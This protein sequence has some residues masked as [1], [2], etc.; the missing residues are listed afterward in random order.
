M[1]GGLLSPYKVGTEQQA[2]SLGG[3]RDMGHPD[4]LQICS[5]TDR[6]GFFSFKWF[7]F[8]ILKVEEE[9]AEAAETNAEGT[10]CSRTVPNWD[11]VK[12][13]MQCLVEGEP[14]FSFPAL[15]EQ[16]AD[17]SAVWACRGSQGFSLE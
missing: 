9:T 13:G 11:E 6:V 14:S 8:F 10:A 1:G 5:F 7:L 15:R 17:F 2:E 3:R 4:K 12:Q 16:A